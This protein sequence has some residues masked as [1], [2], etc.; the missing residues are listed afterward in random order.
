L[1]VGCRNTDDERLRRRAPQLERGDRVVVEPLGGEFFEGRVIA[2]SSERLR[3]ERDRTGEQSEVTPND[4]YRLPAP[5]VLA[6]LGRVA[7]CDVEA[8]WVGCRVESVSGPELRVTT[9]EDRVAMLPLAKTIAPSPVTEL[10]LTQ[11]FERRAA[12]A[13][14]IEEALGA[15][16]PVAP[17]DFRPVAHA[18]VVARREG[19]WWSAAVESVDEDDITIRF[20]SDGLEQEIGVDSL[21][22]EPVN[23]VPL[24]PRGAFVLMRPNSPSDAWRRVR[25]VAAFDSEVKVSDPDG[26]ER[27]VE[28]RDVLALSPRPVHADS[29]NRPAPTR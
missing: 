10:N 28:L 4:V 20:S 12:R 29:T 25:V 16:D 11:R 18:R 17:S 8:R 21:V 7:I 9:L 3:I 2:V 22:P 13:R 6:E 1:L 14:F 15:G 5:A 27:S 19:Q 23:G 24:P 26:A